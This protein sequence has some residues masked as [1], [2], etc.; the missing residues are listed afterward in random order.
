[1]ILHHFWYPIILYFTSSVCC[2]REALLWNPYCNIRYIHF[3]K[4]I[5]PLNITPSIWWKVIE[6]YMYISL[7]F[8]NYIIQLMFIS[9]FIW[10]TLSILLKTFWSKKKTF[11]QF[12]HSFITTCFF[13]DIKH[14]IQVKISFNFQA[15]IEFSEKAFAQKFR[16]YLQ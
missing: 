1:M 3:C 8:N 4:W 2:L 6:I 5:I 13:W 9:G 15:K 12:I 10:E 7:C 14:K 16:F 11:I